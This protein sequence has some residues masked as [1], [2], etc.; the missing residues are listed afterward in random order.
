MVVRHNLLSHR[1][2][3]LHNQFIELI[4]LSFRPFALLRRFLNASTWHNFL[5]A[6]RVHY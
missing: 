2:K 4:S 5:E 6:Q 1:R 3:G